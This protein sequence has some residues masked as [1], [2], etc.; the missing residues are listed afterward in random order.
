MNTTTDIATTVTHSGKLTL[1]DLPRLAIY[2][3]YS[4]PVAFYLASDNSWTV[5]ENDW[6]QTTGKHLN[7]I[8][9]D[10]SI[11]ISGDKFM[12]LYAKAVKK[13]VKL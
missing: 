13:A 3:S 1:I 9:D 2:F 12:K 8:N 11:R 10:K 6:S 7:Y 4:T 5:R